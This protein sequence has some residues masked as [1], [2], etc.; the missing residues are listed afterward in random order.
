MLRVVHSDRIANLADALCNDLPAQLGPFASSK[1]TIVVGNRV[2]GHWLRQRIAVNRGIAVGLEFVGFEQFVAATFAAPVQTKRGVATVLLPVSRRELSLAIASCLASP[3]IMAAAT[4]TPLQDYM[5]AANTSATQARTV[6][7]AE[8]LAD[9]YWAYAQT[10]PQWLRA[11]ANDTR[12]TD[13]SIDPALTAMALWQGSLYRA[14]LQQLRNAAG[15]DQNTEVTPTPMLPSLRRSLGGTPLGLA[16]PLAV[17]GFSYFSATQLEVL[18]ELGEQVDVTVYMQNPCAEFWDDA[19]SRRAS[20]LASTAGAT[21]EATLTTEGSLQDPL[22]LALWGSPVRQTI[23]ALIDATDGD[24]IDA[25]GDEWLPTKGQPLHHLL[26]DTRAR[27]LRTHA[28]GEAAT[29]P[30]GGSESTATSGTRSGAAPAASDIVV[31]ACPSRRRELEVIGATIRDMLHNDSSLHATDIAVLLAGA[32]AEQYFLGVPFAFERAG[33]LPFHLVDAPLGKNGGAADALLAILALPG[34]RFTRSDMLRV[35]THPLVMAGFPH[36][37]ASDWVAWTERLGIVHGRDA[38]DHA[39]T[40]LA[41]A[42]IFDWNHG[43]RRLALGNFAAGLRSGRGPVVVD[44]VEFAPYELQGD[45]TANAAS[46]ALLARSLLGDADWLAQ[47]RRTLAK[48]AE[49]LQTIV[50]AYLYG[51]TPAAIRELE[52]LQSTLRE[53]AELHTDDRELD[54]VE[55]RAWIERWFGAGR[56]DRGELLVSGVMVGPLATMRALPFRHVFV[57]GL[58]ESQFP[59]G[60]A[61]ATLDLRTRAQRGDVSSK[62]RDRYAFFEA[63]QCAAQTV[64]L[65]YVAQDETTGEKLGPSTVLLELCDALTP[66]VGTASSADTL[67]Q[68]S[69]KIPMFGF[70]ATVSGGSGGN[71][72]SVSSAALANEVRLRWADGLRT[73]LRAAFRNAG[74]AIPAESALAAGIVEVRPELRAA[75]G[76]FASQQINRDATNDEAGRNVVSERVLNISVFRKFF[77]SPVQAWAQAVLEMRDEGDDDDIEIAARINEPFV[78]N[79]LDRVMILRDV[80]EQS[81]RHP[82][83]TVDALY[84]QSA[85]MRL[86][87]GQ[88]PVGVFADASAELDVAVLNAWHGGLGQTTTTM[89]DDGQGAHSVALDGADVRRYAFGRSNGGAVQ[90]F[91][92]PT[93]DVVVAGR[94]ERIRLVGS[95]ELILPGPGSVVFRAGNI[96]AVDHLR[97]MIDHLLLS[98]VAEQNP[99]LAHH[100]HRH[101]VI[102]NN[103]KAKSVEHA[104]WPP[105][106]AQAFVGAMLSE[107]LDQDHAYLLPFEQL[108]NALIGKTKSGTSKKTGEF[109][110]SLGYGPV[111]SDD[112]LLRGDAVAAGAQAIAQRR[113]GPFVERMTGDH[114]FV[115]KQ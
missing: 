75:L 4:L 48:W 93:V 16:A 39:E 62:E 76:L 98:V 104:P 49:V 103:G 56:G 85:H 66:Y 37:L 54:F 53:I 40:Y 61:A 19:S 94:H 99:E 32:D 18:R 87:E 35:M 63:L 14:A 13:D 83:V 115:S 88:A 1:R 67:A 73:S 2:V 101:T 79:R 71:A 22:P 107:L 102:D 86:L 20:R 51:S 31:L 15:P 112:G 42:P 10:R 38:S 89:A 25:F 44:G 34:S 68:L 82:E 90:L 78:D 12:I 81:L 43:I 77:E 3:Q 26:A 69:T 97:G 111:T 6:Q 23:S 105:G 109:D 5:A 80:M 110:T 72:G 8:R 57:V 55:M 96:R 65:S 11:W 36:A 108:R 84:Q 47:E 114:P 29:D 17:F 41:E 59:A 106:A 113:L 9:L 24:F 33:G 58:G 30:P 21:S 91:P 50:A 70:R 45:E 95:T 60:Q 92:S 74:L 64:T 28:E 46:F 27:L 52:A 100:S 7:L